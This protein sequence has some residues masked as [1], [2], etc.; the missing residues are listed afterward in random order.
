MEWGD[1]TGSEEFCAELV[2]F[3][4]R[5]EDARRMDRLPPRREG[6]EEFFIGFKKVDMLPLPLTVNRSRKGAKT[7][8][9][10]LGSHQDAR[11]TKNFL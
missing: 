7:Q 10:W 5:H 6:H 8:R 11:D 2:W 9:E 1:E 4:Q 3:S